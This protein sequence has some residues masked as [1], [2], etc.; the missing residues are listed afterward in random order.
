MEGNYGGN[1]RGE[2][3]FRVVIPYAQVLSVA[4][5]IGEKMLLIS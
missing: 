3:R 5:A 2:R 1:Y 4:T